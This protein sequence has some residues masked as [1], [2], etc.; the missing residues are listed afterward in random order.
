MLSVESNEVGYAEYLVKI[1][2]DDNTIYD[3]SIVNEQALEDSLLGSFANYR[4]KSQ[5]V[6]LIYSLHINC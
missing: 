4:N 3:P 2:F 6:I 5:V 1:M